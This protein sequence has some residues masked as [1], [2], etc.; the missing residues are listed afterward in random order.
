MSPGMKVAEGEQEL[1]PERVRGAEEQKANIR[2]GKVARKVRHVL[3]DLPAEEWSAEWRAKI[4]F[5][6]LEGMADEQWAE[7]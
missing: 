6:N 7:S 3:L 2:G 4:V 5:E 1:L